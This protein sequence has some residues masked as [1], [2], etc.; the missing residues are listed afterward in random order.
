[1]KGSTG[2]GLLGAMR[3]TDRPGDGEEHR[4]Q[5]QEHGLPVSF[6]PL[7]LLHASEQIQKLT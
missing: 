2:Q 5:S 3:H 1:M 7:F 4:A 6:L